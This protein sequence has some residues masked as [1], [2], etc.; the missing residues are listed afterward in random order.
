MPAGS[1]FE[2]E[3]A[4][5]PALVA[6][7]AEQIQQRLAE[8]V[9][10]LLRLDPELVVTIARGSSEN[11][12]A[13]ARY[14][15]SLQLGLPAACLPPSLASIYGRALRFDRALALA[16]SQSGTSP[17]LARSVRAARAGGAW[18]VGLLNEPGSPLGDE[19]DV[20]LGIG[21]G[22]E[23]AIAATKTFV[24]S[25]TAVLHLIAAWTRDTALREALSGLP[26]VLARCSPRDCAAA[27]RMFRDGAHV[28]VVGRGPA[29]PMAKEL[30]LKL[31][32]VAGLH[33]EAQSAAEL[34][35]GPIATA[36]AA[37]P[38][39][40]FA[41]DSHSEASVREAIGRLRAAGAAVLL[42]SPT[43]EPG[44]SDEVIQVA[45]AG[46]ALLQ[47]LVSLFAMYP[48]LAHLARERGRDPDRS[49]HLAKATRTR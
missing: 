14:L 25:A 12:A 4:E 39:I 6:K 33:A 45:N 1:A 42:L 16:I 40:V 27:T 36:C 3:A 20:E 32:E 5:I 41:G 23:H 31:Q 7:Q 8:V 29:L 43:A 22:H 2:R 21:A 13:F 34:L 44:G 10:R 15:I 47:P 9:A 26:T 49:P 18:C 46:H 48:F 30:A 11:V 35:H 37:T 38:A 24:L 28:F 19:L 17:D